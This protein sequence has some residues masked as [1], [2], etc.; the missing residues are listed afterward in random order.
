METVVR[1]ARFWVTRDPNRDPTGFESAAF[2]AFWL[3]VILM[4]VGVRSS[5]LRFKSGLQKE[6][7]P[8]E[9]LQPPADPEFATCEVPPFALLLGWL[10]SIHAG[11]RTIVDGHSLGAVRDN[12]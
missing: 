12:Q 1:L 11:H 2:L 3:S 6:R 4:I 5:Y 9:V 8:T 10:G 7:L